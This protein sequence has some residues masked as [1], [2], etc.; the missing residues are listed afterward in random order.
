MPELKGKYERFCREYVLDY[1]GTNAAKRAG[2]KE[3]S[4]RQQASKLLGSD[5]IRER[6]RELQDEIVKNLAVTQSYVVQ[7]LVDTYNCCRTP[8]PVLRYDYDLGEMVETGVYQFDS[9]GA[10]KA[11]EQI[12]K[13][14]GMYDRK[15]AAPDQNSGNLLDRLIEG[16]GEDVDTDDLPEVE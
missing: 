15:C 7:Q 9:K 4:A 5:E 10:L 12:G 6:I 14:L 3:K 16:T 11:L 13:H 1:N 2:Y 8:A